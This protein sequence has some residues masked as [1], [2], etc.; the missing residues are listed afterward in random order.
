M[1]WV[2]LHNLLPVPIFSALVPLKRQSR[3]CRQVSY[4]H[5]ALQAVWSTACAIMAIRWAF[6]PS[7]ALFSII[8]DTSIIHWSSAVAWVSCRMGVIHGGFSREITSLGQ[9]G[10]RSAMLYT[11]PLF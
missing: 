7:T 4:H 8:Q 2:F 5:G 6:P 11:A 1:Y 10:G 3:N 9:V